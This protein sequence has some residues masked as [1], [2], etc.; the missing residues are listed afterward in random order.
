MFTVKH[1]DPGGC[2]RVTLLV[3]VSFDPESGIVTGHGSME[4]D[5]EWADGRIF[6]MNE[7]GK[8]VSVYNLSLKK[9]EQ[10]NG[11]R[12]SHRR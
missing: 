9:Q 7:N 6:V 4:G 11:Q 8:T 10:H 2:E 12:I 3:S 1:I 5:V